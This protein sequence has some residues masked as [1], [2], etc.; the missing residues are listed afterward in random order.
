MGELLFPLKY[1]GPT[2]FVMLA[3]DWCPVLEVDRRL[4]FLDFDVENSVGAKVSIAARLVKLDAEVF[5]IFNSSVIDD[6]NGESF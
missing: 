4:H 3:P 2:C 6:G 5:A 1:A